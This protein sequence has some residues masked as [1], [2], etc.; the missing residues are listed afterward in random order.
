MLVRVAIL[1]YTKLQRDIDEV[2]PRQGNNLSGQIKSYKSLL[3]LHIRLIYRTQIFI[4]SDER[5]VRGQISR[6]FI[7]KRRGVA[8]TLSERGRGRGEKKKR[9]SREND[10]EK[11]S[12]AGRVPFA[13]GKS[14][15]AERRFV[16]ASQRCGVFWR[17]LIL[18][19]CHR[20]EHAYSWDTPR[21]IN[22]GLLVIRL[23]CAFLERCFKRN[24]RPVTPPRTRAPI[25]RTTIY[26]ISLRRRYSLPL[27]FYLPEEII[28]RD[29]IGSARGLRTARRQLIS[30]FTFRSVITRRSDACDINTQN[31]IPLHAWETNC[32]DWNSDILNRIK[33]TFDMRA[34]ESNEKI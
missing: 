20:E 1:L 10:F 8:E 12:G 24:P 6:R 7:T 31:A 4:N 23:K 19:R 26:F 11:G 3:Y 18:Y 17:S 34:I 9:V 21:L 25:S 32:A 22:V 16:R 27:R 2:L 15:A 14:P 5:N 28:I 33:Q 29:R 13:G 30:V